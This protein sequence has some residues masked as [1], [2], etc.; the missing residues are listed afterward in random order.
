MYKLGERLGETRPSQVNVMI[1]NDEEQTNV[2]Q[3]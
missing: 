3:L 2:W 1:Y